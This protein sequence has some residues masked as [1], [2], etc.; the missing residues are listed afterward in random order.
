MRSEGL[1]RKS[2]LSIFLDYILGFH[3]VTRVQARTVAGY[4]PGA[5]QANSHPYS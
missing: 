1:L 3:G 2:N 4:Y 5:E